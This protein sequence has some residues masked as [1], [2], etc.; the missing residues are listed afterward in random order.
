MIPYWTLFSLFAFAALAGGARVRLTDGG[1]ATFSKS[2]SRDSLLLLGVILVALM[3]GFRYEVGGDWRAYDY[4]YKLAFYHSPGEMLELGD[5]AYMLLTWGSEQVGGG[6]LLINLVCGALFSWGLYRLARI[7]PEPWLAMLVAVPYMII[8]VAMGYTRQ[9][10]ALGI[11]MAGLAGLMQGKGII[12]FIPYVAAA[13]LFHKTAII[14]LPVAIAGVYR[15]QVLPILAAAG[16][17]YIL[18]SYLLEG[19]LG[20]LVQNYI[21]AHYSSHG[22]ATRVLMIASAAV[23]FFAFRTRLRFNEVERKIWRNFSLASFAMFAGL[24]IVPSSTVIDRLAL[25]LLPLQVAVIGRL[26]LVTNEEFFGRILVIIYSAAVLFVWLTY[27]YNSG[28]WLP[29]KLYPLP[30]L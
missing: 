30:Y 23:I 2:Q 24:F 8:V 15:R 11:L 13:A 3:I 12:S 21:A 18:Y 4:M 17:G 20:D 6:L 9:A 7:Q 16:F 19:S 25:Y 28:A 27:A 10:V 22:A 5:P 29:Y 1:A 26:S 14:V